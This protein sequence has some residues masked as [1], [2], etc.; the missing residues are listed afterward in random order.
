MLSWKSLFIQCLFLMF[1]FQ[2]LSVLSA[3]DALRYASPSTLAMYA[4][5]SWNIVCLHAPSL[6]FMYPLPFFF[7]LF[8]FSLFFVISGGGSVCVLP[9]G[10]HPAGAH[11][12]YCEELAVVGAKDDPRR[13]HA[14]QGLLRPVPP[15]RHQAGIQCMHTKRKTRRMKKKRKK[16]RLKEEEENKKNKRKKNKEKAKKMKNGET[17]WFFPVTFFISFSSFF[18]F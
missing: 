15:H 6:L 8:F 11:R 18:F 16:E 17:K 10:Q 1:G 5:V 3:F 12:S 13:I 14:Q 2:D 4:P 9:R 7:L